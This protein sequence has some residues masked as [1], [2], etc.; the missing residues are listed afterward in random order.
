MTSILI[1][2]TFVKI[3]REKVMKM[4][5][6]PLKITFY[7]NRSNFEQEYE[8]RFNFFSTFKTNLIIH[9]FDRGERITSSIFELFY[10]PLLSHENLKE[11]IQ[12]NSAEIERFV[13]L[14]PPII[15][16]NIFHSQII[17]EIKSTNDIEG[18][19]STRKE[20]GKA[21]KKRDSTEVV[22]FKGIVNMYMNLGESDYEDIMD[23]VKIRKIYDE[24]FSYDI[25][26]EE[27]P[28]GELFRKEVVYIGTDY[29]RVHQ[30]NPNEE[31]IIKD[32]NKLVLFMNRKDIPF[33]LKCVISHY[34][35]EYIHPFYD[36]NGRMGRFLMSNYLSRKLDF[37]TG[38]T[39]SNAITHNKK[40][41]E[42]AFSEVSNPRNKGDLTL[43]VQDI[44]ELIVEGQND[45]I[46]ELRNAKIKLDYAISILEKL[47][48]ED[49]DM[50][51]VLFI[52]TQGFLYN[53]INEPITDIE[54]RENLN[55]SYP[56]LKKITQRLVER[57]LIKQIK[58][59]P[60][61]HILSK[62]LEQEIAFN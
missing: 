51:S 44:Y 27:Q 29:K 17:E 55:I 47:N 43:F 20:I 39:I 54:L 56:R 15:Q 21:I 22:R 5:Y 50:K 52:L 7:E 49:N 53:E 61:I 38:I 57:N 37:L 59:K 26:E 11:S 18:I 3:E 12:K 10:I 30:G 33:L 40:K 62:E 34:F 6:K 4:D 2:D 42:K 41:Y 16:R 48:L 28:D 9:P 58:K 13:E 23:V 24:L 25:P 46:E 32:L 36:G 45:V 1:N 31:S 14:L 19:Q 8:M 35:F 60:S